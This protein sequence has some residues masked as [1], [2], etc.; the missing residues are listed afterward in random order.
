MDDN[1]YPCGEF[2]ECCYS[3]SKEHVLTAELNSADFVICHP[4]LPPNYQ[5]FDPYVDILVY[6]PS[7]ILLDAI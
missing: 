3:F 2:G 6:C 1:T 4:L 5:M 7:L